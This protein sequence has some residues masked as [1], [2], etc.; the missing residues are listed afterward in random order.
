MSSER[1]LVTGALGCIG[2]WTVKR[3]LDE[4][5]PVWTYDLP[6]DPHRLRLIVNEAALDRVTFIAGDITDFENFERAVVENG[7]THMEYGRP[8]TCSGA[9]HRT[10]N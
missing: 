3:L 6:G 1:F 7:I 2:A 9:Q 5:V 4:N 10:A 8:S